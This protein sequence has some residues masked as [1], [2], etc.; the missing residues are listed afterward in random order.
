LHK[1]AQNFLLCI[2]EFLFRKQYADK[3]ASCLANREFKIDQKLCF[4][5]G[6]N[7]P[8]FFFWQIVNIFTIFLTLAAFKLSFIVNDSSHPSVAL[9]QWQKF[10]AL[11]GRV[12][13]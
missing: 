8:G 1:I 13:V 10:L 11:Y 12:L 9:D 6:S 2:V 4:F 7:F 3:I 5:F